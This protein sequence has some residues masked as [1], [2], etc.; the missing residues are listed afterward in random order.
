MRRLEDW[1]RVP[2]AEMAALCGIEHERW[3]S[4]L[5]WDTTE[6]LEALERARLNG[7]VPGFVARQASGAVA[8]WTYYVLQGSE[9]QIGALVALSPDTTASL[10]DAVLGSAAATVASRTLFFAYTDA[11]GVA[12]ALAGRGFTV[13]AEHY[14][15]RPLV[16]DASHVAAL[17]A[18]HDDDVA[19][20]ARLLQDAYGG[21][22]ATRAFAPG[23]ALADW[24]GYLQQLTRATGCG[25]FLPTLSPV[26]RANHGQLDGVALVT[27]VSGTSAHLAQL[28]VRACRL[29]AGHGGRLLAAAVAGAQSAGYQRISL[30]VNAAN[31]RA[32]RLYA[33]TGFEARATFVSATRPRQRP[34]LI[35]PVA[36]A[37]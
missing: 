23:D 14:L 27:A 31:G 18:W 26:L 15:S 3:T 29:G 12:E 33:A 28:A 11:P 34:G 17:P 32:R 20:A 37:A 5:D 16:P 2:A 22:D 4:A 13:T 35:R 9:L 6:T 1:A 30:L 8:G 19:P 7:R 25:R 36:P 24:H 10:L 21:P